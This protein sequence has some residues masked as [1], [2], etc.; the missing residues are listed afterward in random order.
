M[1]RTARRREALPVGQYVGMPAALMLDEFGSQV[2]SAFGELPYQVG[3][4]VRGKVWRDV[5]VR[6]M[7]DRADWD[8]LELGDPLFPERSGKWVSLCMAYAALGRSMTGLPIDFQI[9]ETSRVQKLY[10]NKPRV[11]L[12]LVPL[13]MERLAK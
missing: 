2:W 8:R 1:K 11:P 4:S 12:G 13:R 6:L 3:S 10:R 5:D 7:L 9:Q